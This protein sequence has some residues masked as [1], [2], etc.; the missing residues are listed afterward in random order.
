M[1][2]IPID[3]VPHQCGYFD[4]RLA[5]YES[6]LLL[7][8]TD[9]EREMLLSNGYRSFG[10]YVFRPRCH[11]C[12]ACTPI[13]VPV[14]TFKPSKSQRRVLKK[15]HN[16]VVT[17]DKPQY[18]PEK[19]DIY[20]DHLK[21][22]NR[23]EDTHEVN[24]FIGSFYDP[25]IPAVEFCYRKDAVLVAVGIVNVTPH[26]LS[27]VYFMYRRDYSHYSLGTFSV[28]KEIDYASQHQK[29][30]LYLGYYIADN[31]FM[32]YKGDFRPNEIL[33]SSKRWVPFLDN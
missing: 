29:E 28:M 23:A 19:F 10:K 31:H 27:S 1:R 21:R 6:F 14:A 33:S 32:R 20:K 16:I 22:F 8:A 13:R 25:T 4:D 30:H 7:E 24:N 17:V 15:C 2:L 18:T 3:P 12:N 26:A 11:G 9:M 5:T